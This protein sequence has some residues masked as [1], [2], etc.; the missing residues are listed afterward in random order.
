MRTALFFYVLVMHLLVFV[1]TYHWSHTGGCHNHYE[2]DHEQLAHLP[3][4]LPPHVAA[5][6]AAAAA[7]AGAGAAAAGGG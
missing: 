6:A 7:G 2:F 3:P 4:E 5:Q 1:T